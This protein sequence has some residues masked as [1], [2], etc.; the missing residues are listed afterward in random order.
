DPTLGLEYTVNPVYGTLTYVAG[1][2]S[3]GGTNNSELTFTINNSGSTIMDIDQISVSWT[4][5]SCWECDYAYLANI[6]VGG[7]DYWR[8]NTYNRSAL[9]VTGARLVLDNTLSLSSGNTTIGPLAFQDQVDGTGSAQPMTGVTFN[10][11]FFSDLTPNQTVSF[12]TGGTCAPANISASNV[13]LPQSYRLRVRLNN[14]GD[15]P[16]TITGMLIKCDVSPSP[17]LNIIAF[18]NGSNIYWQANQSWCGNQARQLVDNTNGADIT[19][20]KTEPP[21]TIGGN[22]FIYLNRMDFYA[23]ATGNTKA[24]ISGGNFTLTLHFKCG[25]DQTIAFTMP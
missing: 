17:Y 25:S 8:W 10:I 5:S 2:A 19:F 14:T 21:V 9:A 7:T 4:N 22:S 1:S 3:L 15:A 24:N 11:S 18:I 20:C 23:A 12:S 13:S 16:A 6:S